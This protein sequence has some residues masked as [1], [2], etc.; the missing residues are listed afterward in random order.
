[1]REILTKDET[2]FP[3]VPPTA[4]G[5]F[6]LH[7]YAA[8]YHLI[9]A[10]HHLSESGGPTL[11]QVFAQFPFL[12]GYF[13]EMLPAMPDDVSW[14]DGLSWWRQ[15]ITAWE[16]NRDQP[17]PLLALHERVGMDVNGRIALVLVGLVEEDSRFGTLFAELQRPLAARRPSLE[18]VTRIMTPAESPQQRQ[19]WQTV[20]Q[21]QKLGLVSV[22][23]PQAPRSE[24]VLRIPATLWEVIRDG[25]PAPASW[26]QYKSQTELASPAD[27]IFPETFLVK[28]RQIPS[29]LQTGKASAVILRGSPGSDRLRVMEAVAQAMGRGMVTV[30]G[31]ALEEEAETRCLGAFCTMMGVLPVLLFDLGPGETVDLTAIPG[32]DGPAGL[33]LGREG[34]IRGE[35]AERAVT[36]AIPFLDVEQRA[37]CWQEALEGQP[38]A[39]L[40]AISRRFHLPGGYIRQ[41]AAGATANAA[42]EQR[43]MVTAVDVRAAC[44]ALNHQLLDTLAVPMPAKGT[45]DG[46]IVGEGTAVKLQE[47]EQRC[48]H[49]ERVLSHL[50]P[51]FAGSSNRGVRAL[52]TGGSGTGKTLAARILAAELGMDLYRVD[53]A[54]VV[55]KYIGETEKI[56]SRAEELDVILLL[57]EGDALLGSRTEVRSAND[58]YAN[59]ETNYLLQRLESY[60]GIVVVTTNAGEY[61]DNAFQRRMDVVVNFIAPRAAERRRIWRLHLPADHAVTKE[62]L[63]RVAV[64]CTLTGGQIRN[65][66]LHATLLAVD[67]GGAVNDQHLGAA[68]HSEYRK[69]GATSPL[70]DNG[71]L[72]ETHG[73]VAAF[74]QILSRESHHPGG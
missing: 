8:V 39:D 62:A 66:A 6:Q 31:S 40:A 13:T 4:E 73:G 2:P 17:L 58:R 60:Q 68:I 19:T 41:A 26:C 61:I 12:S 49:R 20:R 65:A 45:W 24:W 7:F 3:N 43:E 69:A 71:R 50:A 59:L 55:N 52:F 67:N 25:E 27:L 57:D 37:R 47:L 64:H 44:R 36:L 63:E 22:A 23:N 53:L 16:T 38:V 35:I 11:K 46:L 56:L 51:A 14:S 30:K 15:T 72:P 29:L 1:M 10:I 74:L 33:L 21:W 34:G 70:P 32:Y 54:A 18:L 48:R 9:H 5:H 28:V 42:L